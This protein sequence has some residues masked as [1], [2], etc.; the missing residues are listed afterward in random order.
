MIIFILLAAISTSAQ[1]QT[2]SQYYPFASQEEYGKKMA[3]LNQFI[4]GYGKR[5]INRI[6]VAK[7][8]NDDGTEDLFG[9]WKED[10]SILILYHFNPCD[11]DDDKKLCYSWAYDKAR[12]DLRTDV[13]PTE[14]DIKGS[15]YLVDKPWADRIVKACLTK[16]RKFV[17]HRSA[18][19]RKRA[20]H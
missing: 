10:N 3:A 20:Y 1:S 7:V 12:V 9:Y 4:D 5:G 6:F 14:D 17:I 13:V 8:K 15:T 2:A 11:D 18:H 19:H 16:G